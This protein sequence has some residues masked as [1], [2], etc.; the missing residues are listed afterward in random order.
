M[1][2]LF[3]AIFILLSITISAA[4]DW[5]NISLWKRNLRKV[6][7]AFSN[8]EVYV[9]LQVR[10]GLFPLGC[11]GILVGLIGFV[12]FLFSLPSAKEMPQNKEIG[13]VGTLG[14]YLFI[15]PF[16][17]WM[18]K[19]VP[20]LFARS[21]STPEEQKKKASQ[22]QSEYA[23]KIQRLSEKISSDSDNSLETLYRRCWRAKYLTESLAYEFDSTG[24]LNQQNI[25]RIKE[26]IELMK[27]NAADHAKVNSEAR[28]AERFLEQVIQ[29]IKDQKEHPK[30]T[31]LM[32]RA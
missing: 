7:G 12:F 32:S 31:C 26:D 9:P 11:P 4:Y 19:V 1:K 6:I 25:E 5:I 13:I 22:N 23:V 30:K 20:K 2:I 24:E 15:G 29:T 14:L 18:A 3:L 8:D 21:F 17:I 10:S 28:S 27:S 16:L